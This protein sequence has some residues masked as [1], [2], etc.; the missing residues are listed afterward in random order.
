MGLFQAVHRKSGDVSLVRVEHRTM[1]ETPMSVQYA[2]EAPWL[3]E[4]TIHLTE[5]EGLYAYAAA[6]NR[7][8][9]TEKEPAADLAETFGNAQLKSEAYKSPS[10]PC[11]GSKHH[12]RAERDQQVKPPNLLYP[13]EALRRGVARLGASV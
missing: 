8:R 7:V 3:D 9:G 5:A 4:A 1:Y 11:P 13:T 12:Q 2:L 10:Q 6:I